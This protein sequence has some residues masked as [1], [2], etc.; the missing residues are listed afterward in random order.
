LILLAVIFPDFAILD[1]F[2]AMEAGINP[3][4]LCDNAA[5]ASMSNW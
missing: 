3:I 1:M 5:A 4:S 2:L